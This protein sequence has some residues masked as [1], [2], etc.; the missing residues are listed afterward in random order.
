MKQVSAISFV[1]RRNEMNDILFA[2][3]GSRYKR[4]KESK[5]TA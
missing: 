2:N 1:L 3:I 5:V 4:T